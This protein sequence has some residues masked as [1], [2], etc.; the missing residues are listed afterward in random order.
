MTNLQVIQWLEESQ[1]HESAIN[2]IQNVQKSA[3][4]MTFLFLF[5]QILYE[6]NGAKVYMA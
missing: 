5:Q 1:D 2:Q 4:L 6:K 3:G